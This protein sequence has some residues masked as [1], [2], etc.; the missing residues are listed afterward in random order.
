M[1]Q[2]ST[3][4]IIIGEKFDDAKASTKLSGGAEP[5]LPRR[6]FNDPKDLALA[7]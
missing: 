7:F 4:N 2:A 1:L 6:L 3:P 5:S